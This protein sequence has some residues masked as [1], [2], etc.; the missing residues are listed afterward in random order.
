MPRRM[1][2]LSWRYSPGTEEKFV[3]Y[4]DPATVLLAPTVM[5]AM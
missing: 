2:A 5:P 3:Q 1:P 4:D